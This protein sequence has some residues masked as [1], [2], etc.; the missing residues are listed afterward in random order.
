MFINKK[1]IHKTVKILALLWLA[2]VVAHIV[3]A[4]RVFF[5]NFPASMPTFFFTVISIVV[6]IYFI[7]QKKKKAPDILVVII[8]LVLSVT[9]L[10]VVL[11]VK[12]PKQP[13]NGDYSTVRVMSWN[14][15][16]WDQDKNK[17]SFYSFIKKQ[18]A[19]IYLLQEYLH[20]QTDKDSGKPYRLCNIVPGF[21]LHYAHFDDSERIKK[22][23]PGYNFSINNQFVIISRYPIKRSYTDYS[24]QYTVSDVDINGRNVRFFNVHMLLHMETTNP[25]KS[26]FYDIMHRRYLA[27]VV[28]F[29]DLERDTESAAKDYFIAG[30][31]NSS[32]AMGVMGRLLKENE[33]GARYGG[34]L[35]P[36]TY[37]LNGFKLWRIDYALIPKSKDNISFHSYKTINPEGLSDHNPL[38]L[39]LDI[40]GSK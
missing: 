25:F 30:D 3:L 22:E 2:F 16:M 15:N 19:D 31:F 14:T 36:L 1:N 37:Q 23:F 27:R 40:K 39:T 29:R 18:N 28:G 17:D 4:G 24:E 9:Q 34:Q 26:Y 12:V 13:G 32:K 11:P 6:L 33:D 21:P 35:L 7:L 8:A 5:W 10:D 38:F 20:Y